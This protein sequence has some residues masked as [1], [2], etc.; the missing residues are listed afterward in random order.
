MVTCSSDGM[1]LFWDTK[2]T[3]TSSKRAGN[4]EKKNAAPDYV[5]PG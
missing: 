4:K 5:A 3:D 1:L 2:F